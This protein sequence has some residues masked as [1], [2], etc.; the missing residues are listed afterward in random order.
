N[1]PALVDQVTGGGRFSGIDV[2]DD[3]NV[4]MSLVFHFGRLG[5]TECT[6]IC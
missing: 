3:N 4:N 5:L 1:T 2:T 6:E